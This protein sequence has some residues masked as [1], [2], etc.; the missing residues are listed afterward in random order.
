[1]LTLLLYVPCKNNTSCDHELRDAL[2]SSTTPK[3]LCFL[4]TLRWR[5]RV[6]PESPKFWLLRSNV[7][8]GRAGSASMI[9]ANT[10][11]CLHFQRI[12]QTNRVNYTRSAKRF[13]SDPSH[14][15]PFD[16]STR[17]TLR[18]YVIEAYGCMG[19]VLSGSARRVWLLQGGIVL[20]ECY[21]A[22]MVD[23]CAMQWRTVAIQHVFCYLQ[24]C[25][26][27]SWRRRRKKG[28]RAHHVNA[29][30]KK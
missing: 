12:K 21:A 30:Y 15:Y 6:R 5:E 27:L 3:A 10:E 11:A 25:P 14:P 8:I 2:S 4:Q 18:E 20:R 16:L 24:F 19:F 7:K 1:M 13:P 28:S 22:S 9:K 29:M 26:L 23:M 17:L